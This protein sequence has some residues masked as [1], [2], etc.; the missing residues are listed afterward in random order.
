MCTRTYTLIFAPL[1]VNP[2]RSMFSFLLPER[3]R[4]IKAAGSLR[5]LILKMM[6][7]YTRNK[8]SNTPGSIIQLVMDSDAFSPDNKMAQLLELLVAGHDTTSFSIAWILLSLARHPEEQ[9]VLRTSLASLSPN[10]YSTSVQLKAVVKEGMRLYPVAAAGSIRETGRDIT[11]NR[12]EIIPKGSI[13]FLPFML[14]FRNK[15][16]YVDPD[17]FKPNRWENPTKEMVDAFNPFSLGKQN[18]LGQSLAQAETFAIVARIVT[19]FELSVESEGTVD[20]FLTLK[21]VGAILRARKI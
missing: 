17:K 11:T 1:I 9:T 14:Q 10:E 2:F 5:T 20:F 4:A 15:D 13:C 8:A 21:P 18:C 7:D 19:K 12:N 16:I 6:D 3:K